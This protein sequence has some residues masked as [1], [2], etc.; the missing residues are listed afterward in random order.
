MHGWN[1]KRKQATNMYI[2]TPLET[3]ARGGGHVK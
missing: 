2:V 1:W 3:G